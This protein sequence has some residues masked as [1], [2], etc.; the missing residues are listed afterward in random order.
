MS[1]F[2][3][4]SILYVTYPEENKY[5]IPDSTYDVEIRYVWVADVTKSEKQLQ[6]EGQHVPR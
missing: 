4:E 3:P 2:T 1:I 6:E 5:E